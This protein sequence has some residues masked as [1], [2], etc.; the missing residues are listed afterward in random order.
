M[1]GGPLSFEPARVLELHFHVGRGKPSWCTDR[2]CGWPHGGSI[3]VV[4]L[5]D[6]NQRVLHWVEDAWHECERA[7]GCAVPGF[8][9]RRFQVVPDPRR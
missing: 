5:A 4:E 7:E 1:S 3:Q 2:N 8:Q 6:E 9:H